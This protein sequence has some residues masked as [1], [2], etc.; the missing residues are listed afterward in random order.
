VC[1]SAAFQYV[2]DHPFD[3][4]TNLHQFTTKVLFVYS[5]LNEAYGKTHAQRVSSAYP[6]VQLVEISGTGHEIPYFG[7]DRFYPIAK[8]Y[9]NTIQ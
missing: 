7:W 6:D 2:R 4:T 8:T 1:N 5:E 9:L 3:F